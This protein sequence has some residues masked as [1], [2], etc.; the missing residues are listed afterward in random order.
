MAERSYGISFVKHS[1]LQRCVSKLLNKPPC[2][3]EQFSKPS[4]NLNAL[5]ISSN[6][7]TDCSYDLTVGPSNVLLVLERGL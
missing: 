5:T 7:L 6:T 4:N 3:L 1:V 2:G